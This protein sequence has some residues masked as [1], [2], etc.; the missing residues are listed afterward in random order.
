MPG[1]AIGSRAQNSAADHAATSSAAHRTVGETTQEFP[2][3]SVRLGLEKQ[4]CLPQRRRTPS[5]LALPTPG[6]LE[7]ADRCCRSPTESPSPNPKPGA[8]LE[9]HPSNSHGLAIATTRSPRNGENVIR[10]R[11]ESGGERER[12]PSS[13]S[14]V[15]ASPGRGLPVGAPLIRRSARQPSCDLG[16][17]RLP[18][19]GHGRSDGGVRGGL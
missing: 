7:D 14:L 19:G 10:Q 13:Q 6:V 8:T 16:R 17:E 4:C 5:I 2:S 12:F 11:V 18:C 1:R 15:D 9:G 3:H